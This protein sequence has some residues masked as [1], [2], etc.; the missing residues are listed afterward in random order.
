MTPVENYLNH[1]DNIFEVE[2]LFFK[3]DSK[4]PGVAGVTSI[5][6]K[7]LPEEGLI[8]SFT[9]GLSLVKHEDWKLG[10]GE[11]CLSVES[12]ELAWGQVTGFLANS[13]RGKSPFSYGHTINFGEPIANDSEMSAFLIFAPAVIQKEHYLDINIGTDYKVNIAGLYP[14][15]EEE[16]AVYNKIGLEKFWKHPDFDPFNVRRPRIKG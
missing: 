11:L 8:T 3:N 13:L 2:P 7:D 4:Q 5:V 12:K 6:Y 10:R 16:I 1:L 9:Y 15:Y 14:I